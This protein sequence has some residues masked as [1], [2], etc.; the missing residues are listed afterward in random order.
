MYCDSV[1]SVSYTVIDNGVDM[2]QDAELH[3]GGDEHGVCIQCGAVLK[4]LSIV[5]SINGWEHVSNLL[6]P[7]C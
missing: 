2:C 3:V 5:Y 6:K 1:D 7:I 4:L